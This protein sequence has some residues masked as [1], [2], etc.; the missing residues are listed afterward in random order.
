MIRADVLQQFP[1][2]FGKQTVNGRVLDVDETITLLSR[3]IDP[4]IADALAARRAILAAPEPVAGKYA[5]PSWEE[6]FEDPISG[7]PWTYRQIVQ[8]LLSALNAMSR[9]AHGP[10][11][12]RPAI[13]PG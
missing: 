2:I 11:S 13:F 10:V 12:S 4:A 6:R 9:G 5:W 1:S 8:G 3:E 7:K